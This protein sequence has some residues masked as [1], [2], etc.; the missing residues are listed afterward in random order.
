[1]SMRR[2]GGIPV[3]KADIVQV[4]AMELGLKEREA[5]IVVD[6]VLD[7]I[8]ETLL[9]GGRLEIRNFGVFAIKDRKGH[10]GR[11]PKSRE[12]YRI[13]DHRAVTFK[14]GLGLKEIPKN[15]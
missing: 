7:C 13:S 11:N 1:M 14:G 15:P 6:A 2:S 10:I 9:E 12:I 8:K 3:I 5:V 4:V